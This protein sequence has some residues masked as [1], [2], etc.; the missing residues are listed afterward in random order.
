M[1]GKLS[2][3]GKTVEFEFLDV[4]GPNRGYMSHAIFTFI[5]ANFSIGYAFIV[6]VRDAS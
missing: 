1:S 5:K 4:A 6:S 2:P 3:D